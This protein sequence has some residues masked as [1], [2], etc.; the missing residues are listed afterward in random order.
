MQVSCIKCFDLFGSIRHH[1]HCNWLWHQKWA[2]GDGLCRKRCHCYD[3]SILRPQPTLGHCNIRHTANTNL[4]KEDS[5]Y[6]MLQSNK[7]VL[8]HW[9][10]IVTGHYWGLSIKAGLQKLGQA[11]GPRM[12]DGGGKLREASGTGY[13]LFGGM[14]K[15]DVPRHSRPHLLIASMTFQA[16][17]FKQLPS[18]FVTHPTQNSNSW[19]ACWGTNSFSWWKRTAQFNSLTA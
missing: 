17:T 13:G 7:P 4:D 19:H 14:W 2:P 16:Q 10:L 12:P 1:K 5:H 15:N 3:G 6:H 18:S 9:S 11:I 8:L